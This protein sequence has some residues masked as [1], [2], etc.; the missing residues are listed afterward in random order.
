LFVLA[1]P[2][3]AVTS[4]LFARG[5]LR[6]TEVVLLSLSL[7]VS[8]AVLG[9]IFLHLLPGKLETKTW[10]VLLVA[11][12][13]VAGIWAVLRIRKQPPREDGRPRL[14]RLRP[15]QAALLALAL[16]FTAA[17]IIF[18]RTPLPASG[19]RGYTALSIVPG[20]QG[21]GTVQVSVRSSE[22]DRRPF[23]LAVHADARRTSEFLLTLDPGERWSRRFRVDRSL[24]RVDA[25]LFRADSP[26]RVYRRV[27]LLLSP[28]TE[29]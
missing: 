1:I 10:T 2:G 8:I 20:P 7:S 28:S 15:S 27:R 21:S 5:R 24:N 9:S 25:R 22:L 14:A 29:K 3:Y 26:G 12:T 18:A 4:A 6:G 13:V 23:R 17:A 16:L 19:V 11:T